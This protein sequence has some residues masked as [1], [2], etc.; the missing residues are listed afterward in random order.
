M[1][2]NT[3]FVSSLGAGS[4]ID[5]K[6]LAQSLVDAE[7]TP[8][9]ERIDAKIKESET[10]ISGYGA[11][12]YALSQL[13]TSFESMNDPRDFASLSITNTQSTAFSVTTS[14]SAKPASLAVEVSQ[15]AK[16]QRLISTAFA[17]KTAS[18]GVAAPF[19][20][21][22]DDANGQ[23]TLTVTTA[24]PEGIA[25]AINASTANTGLSAQWLKTGQGYQLVVTG[26]TGSA[27]AYALN[28]GP[29]EPISVNSAPQLDQT[30]D[31]VAAS[32]SGASAVELSYSSGGQ[33]Q[34]ISLTRNEQGQWV[35]PSGFTLPNDASQFSTNATR[36]LFGPLQSAQD[37][38]FSIDG[39]EM[40]SDRNEV[41]DAVEGV[42]INLYTSTQ[43]AAKVDIARQS[44]AIRDNLNALV[45]SFNEFQDSVKV[46]QD[47][48]SKVETYG[49]AL[50]NDSLTRRI[51][52]QIRDFFTQDAKPAGEYI[53]AA[54]DVGLSLDRFGKL[55]LDENKLNQALDEHYDEVVLMFTANKND[56][57]LYSKSDAGLAGGA[58]R[59]LDQMLRSTSLIE[60][61]S[62]N[63]T[64]KIDGYKSQLEKLQSQMDRLLERYMNQFTIMDNIVGSSNS[65]RQSLKNSLQQL[66]GNNNN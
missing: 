50:R 29:L 5:I 16:S 23:Q 10:R 63:E 59:S 42:T 39:V 45:K 61:Q 40:A 15:I 28:A 48:G 19:D 2:T 13:K 46:L 18:L 14:N 7:Q 37:A 57:S 60:Q 66:S 6:A 3:N 34:N 43:G 44:S 58:V 21:S 33:T 47:A 56:K 20:L 52:S 26:K 9:K 32:A 4:G 11:L 25:K 31:F 24:T 38:R 55:S 54:R 12:K 51:Q 1:A 17:S 65:T 30:G 41:T 8:R 27:N 64:K 36:S 62:N 22:L 35:L 53:K 49:G